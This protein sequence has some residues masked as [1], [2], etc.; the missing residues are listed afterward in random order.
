MLY[1][2]VSDFKYKKYKLWACLFWAKIWINY[3]TYTW[4][5]TH[6]PGE[7]KSLDYKI[8][9]RKWA[10]KTTHIRIRQLKV[11]VLSMIW[12]VVLGDHNHAKYSLLK[13]NYTEIP[14]I[15]INNNKICTFF[16]FWKHVNFLLKHKMVVQ[17]YSEKNT[18][19]G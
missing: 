14:R 12:L 10:M 16:K 15:C 4:V 2:N 13:R 9:Q 18:N 6:N 11:P 3:S 8:T 7:C 17:I 5:Y 19:Y 1:Q